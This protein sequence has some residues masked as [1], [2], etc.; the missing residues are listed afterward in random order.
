MLCATMM[1]GSVIPTYACDNETETCS[2]VESFIETIS[3][4]PLI[5]DYD[6]MSCGLSN[7]LAD[8][9]HPLHVVKGFHGDNLDELSQNLK[10][11]KMV[12]VDSTGG[13]E[14]HTVD[15]PYQ[16]RQAKMQ[17]D[18]GKNI[19]RYYPCDTAYFLPYDGDNSP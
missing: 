6:L 3:Q 19:W 11:K 9:D 2:E 18:D 15:I 13:V 17:E 12:G 7:N 10:T 5:D 16:A 14:V 8:F 1:F 4:K